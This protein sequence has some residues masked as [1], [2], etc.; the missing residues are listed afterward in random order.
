MV[1]EWPGLEAESRQKWTDHPRTYE[2]DAAVYRRQP[3]KTDSC[4]LP[5][6]VHTCGTSH[7]PRRR[8]SDTTQNQLRDKKKKKKKSYSS[9]GSSSDTWNPSDLH[10]KC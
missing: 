2:V 8:S 1:A 10:S 4:W 9:L 6:D 7:P 5:R 3:I